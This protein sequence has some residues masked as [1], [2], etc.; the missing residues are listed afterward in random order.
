MN[1]TSLVS[2]FNVAAGNCKVVYVACVYDSYFSWIVL[3]HHLSFWDSLNH[4]RDS[5]FS[6]CYRL[7]W[8]SPPDLLALMN[9][10]KSKDKS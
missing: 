6:F 2:V 8:I 1:F 3:L 9:R 4:K 10:R 7:D 5:V